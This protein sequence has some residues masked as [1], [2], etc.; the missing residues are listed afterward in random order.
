VARF[1]GQGSH[2]LSQ[3]RNART[4]REHIVASCRFMAVVAL[5]KPDTNQRYTRMAGVS[6]AALGTPEWWGLSEKPVL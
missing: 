4:E 2:S 3:D 1:D 6:K 5:I